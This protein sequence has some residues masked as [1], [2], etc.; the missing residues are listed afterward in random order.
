MVERMVLIKLTAELANETS[1]REVAAHS[2]QAL[3]KVP[4]VVAVTAQVAADASTAGSWDVALRI[5]FARHEDI[6]P[7]AVHPLHVD[8]LDWLTPR[9]TFKKAWNFQS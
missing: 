6:A 1:R 2:E 4:G 7:Y 8:Y 3:A 9:S 5:R